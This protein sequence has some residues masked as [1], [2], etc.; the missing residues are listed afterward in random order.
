MGSL[1]RAIENAATAIA[2]MVRETPVEQALWLSPESGCE[3]FFKLENMQITG[4]FKVR[5]AFNKVRLLAPS[6]RK[7]GVIAASSGNHGLAVAYAA[8]QLDGS[9]Q[10][11]VPDYADRSKV[12]AIERMG[13]QVVV[14]G[15]DCVITEA[16]ARSVAEEQGKVYISPY[17]DLDVVA[18]QGT[19]AVELARQLPEVD[20]LFVSVGGGG[21][22]SG[23]GAY[24]KAHFPHVEIVA[25]SP[26]Q[27]PAVH[28][29]LEA[30]RIIDVPCY[31]T[32]SDATAGGVEP[33][34]VTFELC[35]AVID[36]MLLVD[37]RSIA[38]ALRTCIGE[39]HILIEGA[40]ALAIAG[41]Q[42]IAPEYAGKRVA[43]II[44]GA[45]IGLDKLNAVLGN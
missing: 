42:Q 32:L 40:A 6:Q 29:C 36:R 44:C 27:S 3:V 12:R 25:V 19:L 10:I 21:L 45:N 20:A 26:A 8:R 1:V 38:D 35:R 17:N 37:E 23:M 15:D 18:G 22:I 7:Q 4:S 30:G 31:P 41:F 5:G 24:Y 34:S 43:V 16:Y 2:P 33:G 28:R 14:H 11:F 39:H 13:A 9:A